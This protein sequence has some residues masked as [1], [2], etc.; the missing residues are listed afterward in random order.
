MD[1]LKKRVQLGQLASVYGVKGWLKVTSHTQPK[2]NIFN[3][4]NWQLKINNQWQ[5]WQVE[6][7]R[8]HGKTLVVKLSGIEDRDQAKHLVGT[9]IAVYR[10]QLP[11]INAD[12]HYWSDL[13]G[14]HVVTVK[15][16]TLGKV[17]SL[18]E[19]GSNDVLV[20]TNKETGK[21]TESLIPWLQDDVIINVN[22]NDQ[23]ITVNWDGNL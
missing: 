12:E 22:K 17:K 2:E 18:L 6:Q 1:S 13:I 20:V 5:E 7:G 3:Y 15:G 11:E 10:E 8:P 19:T 21:T 14:M 9:Q 4:P 16:A 23:I